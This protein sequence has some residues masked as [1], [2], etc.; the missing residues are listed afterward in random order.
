MIE[1]ILL[2]QDNKVP[3]SL[4]VKL[5][6]AKSDT[7]KCRTLMQITE[8]VPIEVWPEYNDQLKVLCE[9]KIRENQGN[10]KLLK[11]YKTFLSDAI[12]NIG[13]LK[14]NDGDMKKALEYYQLSFDVS[15]EINDAR[16][17][18]SSLYTIGGVY[19][20]Q[21]DTKTALEYYNKSIKL[22]EGSNDKK[23][24]SQVYGNM[25]DIFRQEGDAE[26]SLAY[27]TKSMKLQQEIG[28]KQGLGYTLNNIGGYYLDHGQLSIALEYFSKS[29]KIREQLGDREGIAGSLNVLGVVYRKQGEI[30]KSLEC[31]VRCLKLR[32][33][34][35]DKRGIANVLHNVSGIYLLKGDSAKAKECLDR[36]VEMSVKSG[37]KKTLAKALNALAGLYLGQG[38]SSKALEYF[39]QSLKLREEIADKNGMAFSLSNIGKIYFSKKQ[40]SK[41][42]EYGN[43]SLKIA[44]EIGYP[45]N[46]RDAANLLAMAYKASGNNGQALA[47]YELY[48]RMRDSLNNEDTRKAAIKTQIKYDFDKK[49]AADSVAHAK[50]TEINKAQLEKQQAELKVKRNQQYGLFGGLALVLLFS[51]FM[52]NRFKVTQ[53]QKTIIEEQKAIVERQKFAVEEQKHIIEEKHREIT[54]SINYAERIQRSFLA[55]KEMLDQHF[56]E[57]FIFFKPKDVVS[58]DFYW[59]SELN[60]NNFAFSVA[61]STG[62]GVPGAIM[63]LLNITSLERAIELHNDPSQILNHTRRTIIERLKKDGSEAGG[64]DGMDCGMLVFDFKNRKLQVAAANNPVWIAR[65]KEMIEIKPDKMPVGKHDLDGQSFTAHS[66]DLFPGDV[67]YTLTDGFPDQFGGPKGKKFMSKNLRELLVSNSVL[68]LSKQKSIL[69]DTFKTWAGDQ[70]Q[71]DDVTIAGIRII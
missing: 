12:N 22:L 34:I 14:E 3:D 23:T 31:Y 27:F 67:V 21:R 28:E 69:E 58:G 36:C 66:I 29:L 30:E 40:N 13:F 65:N 15:K 42:I 57:Y 60:N 45:E 68:P 4:L 44:Q 71:V 5:R 10:E 1:Q 47:N 33:E 62:H 11:V 48:I 63:S 6:N 25:G 64:K 59:A 51:I 49:A 18:A 7:A 26:K 24:L 53:K 9:Q 32:E 2:A 46:I 38:D 20:V 52:Y 17:M 50:E 54:D 41:A 61:D 37:D 39:N 19:Q 55:S 35:G 70:E 16:R 56:V 8:S 43:K